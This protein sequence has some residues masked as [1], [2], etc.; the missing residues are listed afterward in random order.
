MGPPAPSHNIWLVT[1][2]QRLT[3]LT[4]LAS[5]CHL[6]D[7]RVW[8]KSASSER[9]G[10]LALGAAAVVILRTSEASAV[11]EGFSALTLVHSR[12]FAEGTSRGG[13]EAGG[14]GESGGGAFCAEL[15]PSL[16]PS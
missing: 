1:G 13:V 4:D 5:T 2:A 14:R 6:E 10:S 3:V 15:S 9:S 16:L 7:R 12:G 11:E 8:T